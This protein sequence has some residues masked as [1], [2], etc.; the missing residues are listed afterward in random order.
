MTNASRFFKS[1]NQLTTQDVLD[2]TGKQWPWRFF[3]LFQAK[4]YK[5]L[6]E[7]QPKH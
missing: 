5:T 6:W 7:M 4:H 3:W 2:N 1:G